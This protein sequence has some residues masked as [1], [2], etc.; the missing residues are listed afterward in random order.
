[1]V[2]A[3]GMQEVAA[4]QEV[5]D[6]RAA[7]M[8]AGHTMGATLTKGYLRPLSPIIRA[9]RPCGI[10]VMTA[11]QFRAS[12]SRRDASRLYRLHRSRPRRRGARLPK[13]A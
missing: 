1:M 7:G 11:V 9:R 3:A 8:R 5:V 12:V 2:A 4:T 6:T 13:T 10:A